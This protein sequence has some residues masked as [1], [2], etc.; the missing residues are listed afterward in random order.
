MR[1]VVVREFGPVGS[2]GVEAFPD[3]VA[4][5]GEVLIDVRAVGLNFS[6]RLMM[7]GKYQ[8]RPELPFVPGRDAAGVVAAIGDGV[9]RCRP[10]D[11]VNAIVTFGAYAEKLAAP[12]THCFRLP[13][14]MEFATGAAMG[15]VYITA[16]L[17]A[18]ERGRAKSGETVLVTGASGGVGLACVEIAHARGATVIAGV[19]SPLKGELAIAHGAAHVVDLAASDLRDS[20]REEISAITGGGVDLV[21]DPVGGDVFDAALRTLAMGG[22][23]ISIGFASGRVPEARANYLLLKNISVGGIY[24]DPH[25][26]AAPGRVRAAFDEMFGMFERGEIYPEIMAIRPLGEFAAALDLFDARAMRGKMVLTP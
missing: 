13:D 21:L 26:E 23:L 15:N 9:T 2:H 24:V 1:A 20:L 6:D 7:Q 17:A 14:D 18:V 12:E 11:R 22:R 10:G 25:F 8:V 4:G 5:P 19:T 16:Y 3:P